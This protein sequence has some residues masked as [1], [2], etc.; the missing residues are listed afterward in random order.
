M[1]LPQMDKMR[2]YKLQEKYG[3][4]IQPAAYASRTKL[5]MNNMPMKVI[6]HCSA[7]K[8]GLDY[9]AND[10]DRWHKERN[11]A[12]IG[13]HYVIYRDGTIVKG[14]PDKAVGAHCT[15]HNRNSIGICYIG[16]LDEL[17]NPKDT[18]TPE[19]RE[20]MHKLVKYLMEM[21]DLTLNQVHCHNQ[22]ANKACPSFDILDFRFEF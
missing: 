1:Y 21:Y 15:G 18:R 4:R 3:I 7:T 5:T 9:T 12:M 19:Q 16:G 10:I 14:R 22:F 17:G 13:Y 2:Q 11:F 20:S 6:L 8:E